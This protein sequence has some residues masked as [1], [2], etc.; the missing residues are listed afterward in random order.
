VISCIHSGCGADL[1][2]HGVMKPAAGSPTQDMDGRGLRHMG[3]LLTEENRP[4][5][6]ATR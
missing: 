2:R 6:F 4:S 3:C 1:G 5:M